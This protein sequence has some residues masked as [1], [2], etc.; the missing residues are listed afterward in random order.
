MSDEYFNDNYLSTPNAVSRVQK[1]LIEKGNFQ[2]NQTLVLQDDEILRLKN[3]LR[4]IKQKIITVDEK[5]IK[6]I[7]KLREK[8]KQIKQIIHEIR[9]NK[10]MIFQEIND[11]YA[12]KVKKAK[13]KHQKNLTLLDDTASQSMIQE[14]YRSENDTDTEI[15]NETIRSINQKIDSI[16]SEQTSFIQESTERANDTIN[17]YKIQAKTKRVRCEELKQKINEICK[18]IDQI[19]IEKKQKLRSINNQTIECESQMS[20]SKTQFL[21]QL[22]SFNDDEINNNSELIGL[23]RQIK[24]AYEAKSEVIQRTEKCKSNF[25]LKK[26]E[27][28]REIESLQVELQETK[29]NKGKNNILP[30]IYAENEFILKIQQ[31]IKNGN[32]ILKKLREENLALRRKINECDYILHG[33]TGSYQRYSEI[34]RLDSSPQENSSTL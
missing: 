30:L 4:M 28:K 34:S 29:E 25:K 33:R 16:R 21:S 17:R 3:A 10:A 27:L 14:K 20:T 24:I 19:R 11:K 2:M 22:S 9:I 13:K 18:S 6:A 23:K 7:K 26:Q 12:K 5:T 15:L 31:K 1:Y 32:G 8:K